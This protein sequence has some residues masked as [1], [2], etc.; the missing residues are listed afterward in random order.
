MVGLESAWK[1]A[2]ALSIDFTNAQSLSPSAK[3]VLRVEESVR[4]E[5]F[6]QRR[7]LYTIYRLVL[8]LV[9]LDSL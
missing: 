8:R 1:H 5:D 9:R 7:I 3:L 4:A 2:E 6:Y